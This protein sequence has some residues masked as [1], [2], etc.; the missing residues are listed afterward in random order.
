MWQTGSIALCLGLWRVDALMVV[1]ELMLTDATPLLKAALPQVVAGYKLTVYWTSSTVPWTESYLE[2]GAEHCIGRFSSAE[3][4]W[5]RSEICG[6]RHTHA[7]YQPFALSFAD[8]VRL[9]PLLTP[10][11]VLLP[12][13][14]AAGPWKRHWE[15]RLYFW[16][17]NF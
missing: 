13:L 1:A 10:I 11:Q 12:T 7:W 5:F 8:S 2:F 15:K 6:G 3:M 16:M 14:R 4:S 17:K 9:R